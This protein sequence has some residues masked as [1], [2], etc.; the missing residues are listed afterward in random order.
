[1]WVHMDVTQCFI[2]TSS[3]SP[4]GFWKKPKWV[5]KWFDVFIDT[6]FKLN[7]T[8]DIIPKTSDINKFSV[9]YFLKKLFLC[10]CFF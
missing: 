8:I 3:I 10:N 2:K 9:H 7:F 1:M 6:I 4:F 5:E